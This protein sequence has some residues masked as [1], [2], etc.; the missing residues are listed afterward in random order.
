MRMKVGDRKPDFV[1]ALLDNGI[2]LTNLAS[3]IS[4]RMVGVRGM[5]LVFTDMAPGRDNPNATL[6]H[7]WLA[8]ETAVLG[9][10]W[11]YSVVTWPGPYEQTFPPYGPG[12][13]VDIE[14]DLA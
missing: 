8:P 1:M 9:R 4:C 12:L 10:I 3:A 14:A 11:I 2:A 5:T 13:P 6:T 7:L